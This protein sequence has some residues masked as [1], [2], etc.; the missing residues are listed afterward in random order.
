M[1]TTM[2][3]TKPATKPTPD[4]TPDPTPNHEIKI[5]FEGGYVSPPNPM[6]LM[7]VGETVRY[8]SNP[9][10]SGEI[11][12]KFPE[13]S[14][15]RVDDVTGTEVPG[16]VILT[17]VNDSGVGTLPSHCFI[18]PPGGGPRIGWSTSTP[19]AGGNVKVTQPR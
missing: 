15:F 5:T 13:R 17:L 3:T 11:T 19:D 12:I 18:T 9:K 16:E 4:P 14:P 1:S 10:G 7:C 8:S 2:P 6:P